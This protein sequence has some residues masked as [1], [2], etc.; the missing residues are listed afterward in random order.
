[1]SQVMCITG[2]HRS[3]TS[4]TTSWLERCGLTIQDGEVH[5]PAVGNPRGHFEDK[6]FVDIH[7]AAI[8]SHFP[9]SRGWKLFAEHELTMSGPLREQAQELA[10]R[11]SL[12]F[13]LWGWKDPRTVFFFEQWKA[14]IPNMKAVLIWRSCEQ[15]VRSLIR[16]SD[17]ATLEVFRIAPDQ[18]IRLWQ[19]YNRRV[20]S[21]KQSSPRDTLLVPLDAI[22]RDDRQVH[23]AI[24]ELTGAPLE[25]R[26]LSEVYDRQ[27][28]DDSS[29]LPLDNVELPQAV[30]DLEARLMTLSDLKVASA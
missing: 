22:I 18:A 23:Q 19:A 10:N 7:M 4:L 2:M 6:A 30:R 8:K 11:R 26:P 12:A 3:G 14:L 28:L 24:R 16:R 25:Y 21:I 1:M 17:K 27:L 5:G 20:C 9:E 15:V 13:D 29:T